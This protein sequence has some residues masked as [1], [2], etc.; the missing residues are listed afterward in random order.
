MNNAKCPRCGL[1]SWA[2][3]SFCG[4]C[5][6]PFSVAVVTAPHAQPSL[7]PPTPLVIQPRAP[8]PPPPRNAPPSSFAHEVHTGTRPVLFV[9]VTLLVLGM[10]GAGGWFYGRGLAAR[11]LPHPD[12]P[13]SAAH[14][15]ETALE[16][17]SQPAYAGTKLDAQLLGAAHLELLQLDD[18][19]AYFSLPLPEPPDAPVTDLIGNFIIDTKQIKVARLDGDRLRL[20]RYSVEQSSSAWYL[21]RTPFENVYFDPNAVLKFPYESVTYDVSMHELIDYMADRNTN[22]GFMRADTGRRRDGL[23]LVFANHG[24][25]VARRGE[26]SLSRFVAALVRDI[27]ADVE[28][29]RER[30]VQRVLDFVTREIA[31]DHMEASYQVELLK[32]PNE[33]LMSG[34]GDCSNK[35]ILLGSLLEQLGEDCLFIYL[36]DHITVAV[37]QGR[38]ENRNGLG[39]TWENDRWLI[40]ESTATGFRIG[41]DHLNDEARFRQFQYVQRPRE[42]NLIYNLATGTPLHFR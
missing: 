33:V 1:V 30:R 15:R 23:P 5:G 32:R 28:Q 9:L 6:T 36:S 29:A 3:T 2:V 4:R 11:V 24:A 37:R 22:G 35:A 13:Y 19:E 12:D 14:V 21:F 17:L 41:L 26:P 27:P 18:R 31:Y 20:G 16:Y 34:G 7:A 38:F 40:A 25:F 10:L 8:L 39:I 42:N